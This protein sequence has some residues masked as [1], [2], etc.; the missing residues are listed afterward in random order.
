VANLRVGGIAA[1]RIPKV[2]PLRIEHAALDILKSEI[3][4]VALRRLDH[5]LREVADDD[6]AAR[7]DERCDGEAA[8]A[9]A[10]PD[11]EDRL[12]PRTGAGLLE[13]PLRHGSSGLLEI[14]VALVWPRRHR[15]QHSMTRALNFG[16]VHLLARTQCKAE[17]LRNPGRFKRPPGGS[18]LP[19][20]TV[21]ASPAS[22]SRGTER[23]LSPGASDTERVADGQVARGAGYA[24]PVN[25]SQQLPGGGLAPSRRWCSR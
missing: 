4:R 23:P 20:T 25:E 24:L 17:P 15:L 8:D 6:A 10:R 21:P 2:K 22:A 13:H 1:T 3:C 5:R 16:G 14:G 19:R 9:R 18:R 11:V 7:P 12:S